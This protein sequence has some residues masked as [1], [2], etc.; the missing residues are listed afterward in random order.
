[1]DW[2]IQEAAKDLVKAEETVVG[3]EHG[4]ERMDGAGEEGGPALDD[5][6]LPDE[7]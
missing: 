4:G 1:M 3:E 7:E 5:E 2:L 6:G